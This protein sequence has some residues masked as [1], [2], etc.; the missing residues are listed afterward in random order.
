MSF[1]G[2]NEEKI[3]F[4]S[5]IKVID[6]SVTNFSWVKKSGQLEMDALDEDKNDGLRICAVCII[7]RIGWI[8]EVLWLETIGFGS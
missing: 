8:Q 2:D 5:E 7:F 6:T 4:H 1:Q 3:G